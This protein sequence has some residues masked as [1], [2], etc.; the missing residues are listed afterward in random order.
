MDV[1]AGSDFIPAHLQPEAW[2]ASR[3]EM[4]KSISESDGSGFFYAYPTKSLT[5]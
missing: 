5:I 1:D 2:L 4:A 3:K